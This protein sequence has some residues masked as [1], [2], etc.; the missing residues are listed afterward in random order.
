ME[1]FVR[2]VVRASLVWFGIGVLIGVSMAFFPRQALVYRTA[3]IHANLLGFVSMMIYGVAYHV[4]PRFSGN[5][6]HS[7]REAAI[8]LWVANLGLALLVGGWIARLWLAG[9]ANA[10]LRTGAALS[11][12]G[13]ALFIHNIWKTLGVRRPIATPV[14]SPA[15][16]VVRPASRQRA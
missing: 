2:R 13:A 3:H 14:V 9:L 5:P 12:V 1:P 16:P 8:H 4:M 7:R 6:L 10:G 15:A 11:A